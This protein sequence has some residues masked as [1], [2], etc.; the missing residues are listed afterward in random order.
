MKQSTMDKYAPLLAPG[1]W[2]AAFQF[3]NACCYEERQQY[4]LIK[5]TSG[6]KCHDADCD[7]VIDRVTLKIYDMVRGGGAPGQAPIFD[8][9]GV[10]GKPSD[11]TEP[12]EPG[13]Q[14][15]PQP[16]TQSFPYPD[17]PTAVKKY[18]DRVRASFN[19]IGRPFPDPN[20]SDAF[21]HFTRYGYDCSKM[22]EPE[23]ANKH[24]KELRAE[25]GAPP[26]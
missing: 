20:D 6:Q 16:P 4:A 14:P 17:E 19:A 3:T 22:A 12:T 5:K 13:S 21:R 15:Q 26:E 7:K 23:S 24:I 10:T 8:D 2:E 1:T 25:L 11:F 18:Q 9:T